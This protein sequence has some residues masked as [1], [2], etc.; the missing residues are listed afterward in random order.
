[1]TVAVEPRVGRVPMSRSQQNMY[2]GAVQADDPGLYLIGKSFRFHPIELPVFLSALE[3]AIAANPVQL[4][5]LEPVSAD[6]HHPE[7]VQRL[8]FGDIVS[9]AADAE[10]LTARTADELVSRWSTGLAVKPLV[11]YTVRTGADARVVGLDIQAHHLLLDG[12]AIGVI[13]A[14]LGRFLATS[15]EVKPPS[16]SEGLANLVAAHRREAAKADESLQRFGAA[17]QHELADAAQYTAHGQDLGTGPS[18]AAKGVLQESVALSGKEF[19][20]L[21]AL[22]EAKRVPLNILVAAASVAVNASLRQ[23]TQTLLVHAVDNRFGEPDL[24]VATCLVNSIAHPVRFPAFASVQDVVRALDRDYV[25]ASRR[26]WLREEHYRR[27]YLAIN[28]TSHVEALTVNF[29][30]ETCAPQLRPFLA[31]APYVTDIGPVEGMTVSCV[32][33]ED[34]RTLTLSIWNR[35]DLPSTSAHQWVAERIAAALGSMEAMWHLPIAMTVNEWFGIGADGA[36]RRGDD[37]AHATGLPAWFLD[38]G[39]EVARFLR[40][41]AFVEPWIAWLIAAGVVPGDIVVCA[42]DDTDKTVD[43]LIACHLSGCGYS[44][45]ESTEELAARSDS[46]A[47]HGS[48]VTV[49]VID[50]AISVPVALDAS[51]REL[52]TERMEQVARDDALADSTA[53]IMATSGSTGEPKLVP[54]SHGAL[55]LFARAASSAYGWRMQDSILQCAPLTSDISVEEI[56]GA[57][58]CGARVVRS[59][60]MKSGDLRALVSDIRELRP[61]LLDLPTA[62]WHLL[63]EDP[64]ALAAVGASDL[65]QVVVGGEAIRPGAVDMWV[66]STDTSGI[67]LI[68]SYGPTET[69]VVVTYLPVADGDDID[70]LRVGLPVVPNTVFVA[71]GEIVVVGEPVSVGYLGMQSESFGVVNAPGGEAR[72]AF[73]TADRVVFDDDGFPT[74]AGRRDAIV[75]ISGKRVDTAAI[76]GRISEDPAVADAYVAAHNGAL[77]V[78]FQA[79]NGLQHNELAGRIRRLLVSLGVSSFFVIDVPSI[80]RQ[81]NGKVDRDVLRTMAEFV[82]AVPD[83]AEAAEA[84]AGLA[85]I[86]SEHLGRQIRAGSSLLAEGIGSLDLIRILP[87][88]RQYLGRELS[89]LDLISADSATYLVAAGTAVDELAALDT[90]A[91][92]GADLD[93]IAIARDAKALRGHDSRSTDGGPIVVLGASGIVGTGF[94]RATLDLKREGA[95]RPEVILVTRSELPDCEPWSALK[96]VVGVK[97]LHVGSEFHPGMLDEL[98]RQTGAHTLI[99][100]IGNT[101]VLAPYRDIRDANVEWVSGAVAAC[102]AGGVRL[103]HMSTFVVNADPAV[104]EVTDPREAVYPYAASKALAELVVAAAPGELDFT[105]VRLPRVLGEVSQLGDGADIL[106]SFVDACIALRACPSVAL[107]EEVTTGDVAARSILGMADDSSTLGR[108]VTVLRGMSVSYAEFLGGF[109]LEELG[110]SEW[111]RLLDRS[112]WATQNPGRWSVLDAW[113]GLGMQ[114]G[115]RSYADYLAGFRTISLD[116]APVTELSALPESIRNLLTQEFSR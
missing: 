97:V 75:K 79:C 15:E 94:A 48:G 17:I 7:L 37:R 93:R 1:M 20:A 100:C 34:R 62:V 60:G 45:C 57:A 105:L 109:G 27:M 85:R 96:D 87:A 33:D 44:V 112:E 76:I 31:A 24:S 108:G 67:A 10:G 38:T 116:A 39:G 102:T 18:G 64:K 74:F 36:R 9:V 107:T 46:I 68:S 19:D 49:R 5:V 56:F 73:A 29:I 51:L 99:N 95:L 59:R 70:R 78:W 98:I 30:R 104:A 106:V 32:A 69:T 12:G 89:V 4:C 13:E 23:G 50:T 77:A 110:L 25:K 35:S 115:S 2:N 92:I 41:R 101:N 71:F 63:C 113:A 26:R 90:A 8:E 43:L 28:R 58:V 111:K 22:A 65:R 54:V 40:R 83:E 80:P 55:A 114:L 88:T 11:H 47:E 16:A 52:V 81:P 42:D 66:K 61:T 6:L 103:I 72:R 84:A 14:D 53:Y 91:D 86:W 82:D 3:G 21:N